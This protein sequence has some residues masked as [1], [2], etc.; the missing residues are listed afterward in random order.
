VAFWIGGLV[1]AGKKL[2]KWWHDDCTVDFSRRG[3]IFSKT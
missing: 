1:P 2:T 3:S